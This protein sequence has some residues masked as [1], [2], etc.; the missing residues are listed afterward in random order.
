MSRA[1]H[2]ND[3]R[4]DDNRKMRIEN[5]HQ[6]YH[7]QKQQMFEQNRLLRI[8]NL[9]HRIKVQELLNQQL[10]QAQAEELL[11]Q[12]LLENALASTGP[13]PQTPLSTPPPQPRTS[14]VH[15]A[16][17][18]ALDMPLTEWIKDFGLPEDTVSLKISYT[19]EEGDA[20]VIDPTSDDCWDAYCCQRNDAF[21][22]LP[23][24]DVVQS[25]QQP[26]PRCKHQLFR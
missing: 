24:L 5:L 18:T 10:I 15:D 11:N 20:I 23:L 13:T 14:Y 9:E 26:D 22:S 3:N 19:D 4:C 7:D 17:L 16:P 12:K 25:P 6:A 2:S 1:P 21:G 8:C